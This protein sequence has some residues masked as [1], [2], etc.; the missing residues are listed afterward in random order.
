[1]NFSFVDD[2]LLATTSEESAMAII[3]LHKA[4]KASAL[5]S[6]LEPPLDIETP[7]YNTIVL[8]SGIIEQGLAAAAM[9]P[10]APST[11]RCSAAPTR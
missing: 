8:N 10:G 5:F 9:I 1:M 4:Q 6:S 2:F 3:D 7:V 11:T